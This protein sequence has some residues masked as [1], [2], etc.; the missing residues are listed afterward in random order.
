MPPTGSRKSK[1]R[2]ATSTPE[3]T[4]I[5]QHGFWIYHA[6]TEYFLPY[7]SNPWFRKATV[8]Q[9]Q[10]VE[11]QGRSILHWPELDID[12]DVDRISSPGK[13]HLISR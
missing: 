8:A 3:V 11:L 6:G 9:I 7:R 13:Y 10:K 2:K 12:L 4:N 1:R 5:S